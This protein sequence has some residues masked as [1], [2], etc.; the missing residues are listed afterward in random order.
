MTIDGEPV[1]TEVAARTFLVTAATVDAQRP[2]R[3]G[4]PLLV[5]MSTCGEG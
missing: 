5:S 1:I 4:G 3:W 2:S